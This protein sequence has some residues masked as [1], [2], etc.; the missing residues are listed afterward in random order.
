MSKKYGIDISKHQGNININALKGQVDFIIIRA[1]YGT[2]TDSMFETYY[3]ACKNAGIPVGAY[4][5]GYSLDSTTAIEEAKY[6]LNLLKGKTFEYPIY[7]D[8]EDADNYKAK[9]GMPSNAVLT[10]ICNKFCETVEKAGYY[11][12]VYASQSWFNNQLR[13]ITKCDKWVA[14]WGTNDGTEQRDT[15]NQGGMLQYTSKK[16]L[17]G[18]YLDGNVAYK[19]YPTIIKNAGLNGFSKGTTNNTTPTPKVENKPTTSQNTKGYTTYTVKAGDTLSGIASKYGTTYQVLA[20]YN[21]ISDPNKIF[22]GQTIKIPTNG[23]NTTKTYTVQKGDTLSS[24]ASKYGTTYQ[25]IAKDNNIS[26]P[27]RIYPG[28]KLI[29]NS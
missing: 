11:V 24:I 10:D 22:V 18:Q 9:H 2:N 20:S 8:M 14:N 21:G 23:S 7:Y 15:S 13:G 28:Q 17:V 4:I 16:Y 19:D 6:M 12:G 25:K 27:N 5:Y 1:C 26:D 3:N 29:I